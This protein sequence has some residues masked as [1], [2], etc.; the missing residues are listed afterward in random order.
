MFV[1]D[2]TADPTSHNLFP[3]EIMIGVMAALI[4]LACLAMARLVLAKM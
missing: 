1:R 3:F 4:Y 2:L